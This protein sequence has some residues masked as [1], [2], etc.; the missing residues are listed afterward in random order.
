M[1][2]FKKVMTK[3]LDYYNHP[4]SSFIIWYVLSALALFCIE[5]ALIWVDAK[6]APTFG[7]A[8]GLVSTVWF[9]VT[10]PM[11]FYVLSQMDE[12]NANLVGIFP[13]LIGIYVCVIWYCSPLLIFIFTAML[14]YNLAKLEAAES[15][16]TSLYFYT[17]I[18]VL[19]CLAA[20]FAMLLNDLIPA[21]AEGEMYILLAT[22]IFIGIRPLWKNNKPYGYN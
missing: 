1:S 6:I 2:K 19:Y 12:W 14:L 10:V 11:F 9:I 13:C 8:D 5:F 17:G 22:A 15:D 3:L 16:I 20:Y 18:F 21:M 7:R 4:K